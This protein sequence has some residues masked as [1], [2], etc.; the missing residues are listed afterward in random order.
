MYII[1]VPT[2][3]PHISQSL[4]E[5]ER[6]TMPVG[7]TSCCMHDTKMNKLAAWNWNWTYWSSVLAL[8]HGDF[9][10]KHPQN[11]QTLSPS[12]YIPCNREG[13]RM[14]QVTSSA[15]GWL[16]KMPCTGRCYLLGSAAKW[17]VQG[18]PP[19]P[20]GISTAD[21]DWFSWF[22]VGGCIKQL[23]AKITMMKQ[24]STWKLGPF[25]F[26][27][28]WAPRIEWDA[29]RVDCYSWCSRKP[30]NASSWSVPLSRRASSK[31]GTP[32]GTWAT[33]TLKWRDNRHSCRDHTR[34]IKA[35]KQRVQCLQYLQQNHLQCGKN[36]GVWLVGWLL[37]G[38]LLVA[39]LVGWCMVY[40]G[41]NQQSPANGY[42]W[43][44]IS[45]PMTGDEHPA[46]SSA[47]V[48]LT[49]HTRPAQA[50]IIRNGEVQDVLPPRVGEGKGL[51]WDLGGQD[52][53]LLDVILGRMIG[54]LNK[55]NDYITTTILLTV[56]VEVCFSRSMNVDPTDSQGM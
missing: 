3:H 22:L 41:V 30:G 52:S 2:A 48:V 45:K 43:T 32:A 46:P 50:A 8:W 31:C 23:Y 18:L 25:C 29:G 53:I 34:D 9:D 35:T 4:R 14:L 19:W 38:C 56:V 54:T 15:P 10:P 24:S 21:S 36:G 40:G 7:T 6:A 47:M 37:I 5:L 44:H 26:C 17:D 51:G 33:A 28:A 42:G 16:S 1:Y 13:Y 39:W 11:I 20:L 27:I 49:Q 55:F 12:P